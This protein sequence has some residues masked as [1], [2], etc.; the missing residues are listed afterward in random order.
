LTSDSYDVES[1]KDVS[2]IGFCG[3]CRDTVE[4]RGTCLKCHHFSCTECW[5]GYLNIKITE[6]ITLIDCP[7]DSC[8]QKVSVDII[9]DH[10]EPDRFKRFKT[11]LLDDFIAKKSEIYQ[12]CRVQECNGTT[13]N[14]E[15]LDCGLALCSLSKKCCESHPGVSCVQAQAF[16]QT[17]FEWEFSY[18]IRRCPKCNLGIIKGDEGCNCIICKC[19]HTYCYICLNQMKHI[20]K[21]K[22]LISHE[23]I[24]KDLTC[25]LW[26]YQSGGPDKKVKYDINEYTSFAQYKIMQD[27]CIKKLRGSR[28]QYLLELSRSYSLIKWSCLSGPTRPERLRL[29]K[30]CRELEDIQDT[31]RDDKELLRVFDEIQR[32]RLDLERSLNRRWYSFFRR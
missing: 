6:G 5:K 9:A 4:Q 22:G 12:Y 24:N 31:N 14:G 20:K 17:D 25:E 8:D 19:G 28:N 1:R 2:E 32:A 16:Q 21:E 10:I 3:I 30:L 11:F 27:E 13:K 15:C 26:T 29:I 23:H 18:R 7:G